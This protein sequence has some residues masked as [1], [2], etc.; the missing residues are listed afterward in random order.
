MSEHLHFDFVAE[1]ALRDVQALSEPRRV[2]TPGERRAAQQIRKALTLAGLSVWRE[3]FPVAFIAK[4]IGNALTFAVSFALV[5]LGWIVL[6]E[7]PWIALV[8]WGLAG[9][10]VNA[11]WRLTEHLAQRRLSRLR[12]R[13]YLATLPL[14]DTPT[15]RSSETTCRVIF[16]AHYDSKSQWL[17]TGVRVALV[18]STRISCWS[19]AALALVSAFWPVGIGRE[20]FLIPAG[21][22]TLGLLTLLL[23]FTGNRSPGALDN[24]SG[25]GA[26]LELS[27]TWRP[28]PE[29]PAE[30][31][32]VATG[33]EEIGLDGARDFLQR[34]EWWWLEKPTLLI[35]LESIGVGDRVYLSG[36]T[37]AVR[38]AEVVASK[39]GWKTSRFE[40]V[41]AGMDHQPFA[42]R[43]LAALSLLG[44]VVGR[45]MDMHSPRD[46]LERVDPKAI[47][48]AGRLAA[49]LAWAWAETHQ[50]LPVEPT[51]ALETIEESLLAVNSRI[52]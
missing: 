19:L 47:E 52:K 11:P 10:L 5:L 23:N 31:F 14:P 37:R 46:R 17:P 51:A 7:W 49:E 24:G 9:Y 1:R 21:V 27:R 45:S 44:D 34:Y 28:R 40:I 42:A 12:S 32:W 6:P 35:N 30:V 50:A 18:I 48:R 13:N 4:E 15:S 8:C 26:L 2:G 36:E 29:A 43:G 16:M 22:A 38:L 41:G 3:R 20:Y 25:L 39:H 33:A